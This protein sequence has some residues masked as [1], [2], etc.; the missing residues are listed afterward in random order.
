VITERDRVLL[1][2]VARHPLVHSGHVAALL[3]VGEERAAAILSRLAGGGYLRRQRVYDQQPA[4]YRIL[5]K[6]LAV[7]G[8]GLGPPGQGLRTYQHD[9]GMAWLWLAARDGIF[10]PLHQIVSEREM[11]SHD[12]AP[13]R[14]GPPLAVRLGGVGRG[15]RERL[16]YPDLL[17]R[18]QDGRTVAI[19]LELTAKSR[20][21][22]DRILGGYAADGRVDAVLYLVPNRTM[23]NSVLKAARR[24]GISDLVHVQLARDELA[25][26]AAAAGRTRARVRPA[27]SR[28]T[29]DVDRTAGRGL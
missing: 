1:A 26:P 15:G 29:P 11:R 2:F 23:G 24:L 25:S 7:I 18:R 10:G 4:C 12:E 19:E 14:T 20:T 28:A 22:L 27:R 9:V 3:S 13:E 17:L 21:R 16:H 8:S 6:G 5:S